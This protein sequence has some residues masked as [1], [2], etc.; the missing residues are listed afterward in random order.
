[1]AQFSIYRNLNPATKIAMPFLLNVQNELLANLDT[2][3]V[4]PLHNVTSMQDKIIKILMPILEVEGERY[5]ML[6]PQLAG[7]SKRQLGIEV[8]NASLFRAEIMAAL[9]LLITGI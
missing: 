2:C 5:V 6:T 1:M 9:D 3:V 8:S 7:I 4:V